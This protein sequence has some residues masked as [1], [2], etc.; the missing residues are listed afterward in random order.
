MKQRSILSQKDLE[1]AASDILRLSGNLPLVI[2]IT[3]GTKTRTNG[4]NARY[5]AE[6]QFFMGQISEAI[7]SKADETGHSNIEIRRM[8]AEQLPIEQALILF[9]KKAEVIHEILKD[10]MGIP[11]STRLGTKEFMKFEDR[12][13]QVMSEIIGNIRGYL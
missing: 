2:T 8:L 12:L 5:W 9:A 6:V 4:Q 7:D 3:E 10:I 11:T 13:S 1:K